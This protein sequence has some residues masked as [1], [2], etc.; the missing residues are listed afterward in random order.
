MSYDNGQNIRH[1]ARNVRGNRIKARYIRAT[2]ERSGSANLRFLTGKQAA[3]YS[4]A[5]RRGN[6]EFEFA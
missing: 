3:R 2:G 5:V 1:T 6:R 4:R